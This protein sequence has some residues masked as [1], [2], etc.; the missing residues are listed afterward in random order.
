MGLMIMIGGFIVGIIIG[1]AGVLIFREHNRF[2]QYRNTHGFNRVE[3]ADLKADAEILGQS[4]RDYSEQTYKR[5][6]TS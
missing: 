1:M 3:R 2:R 4:R 5:D 6:G